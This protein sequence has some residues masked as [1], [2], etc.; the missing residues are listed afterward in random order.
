MARPRTAHVARSGQVF[1]GGLLG[2][3]DDLAV[4]CAIVATSVPALVFVVALVTG[5]R[6]FADEHVSPGEPLVAAALASY[7]VIPMLA[8]TSAVSATV[9]TVSLGWLGNATGARASRAAFLV[10]AGALAILMA[11]VYDGYLLPDVLG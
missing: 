1:G 11:V 7:I 10:A 9:V 5:H 4:R 6:F 3:L 2:S 8:M